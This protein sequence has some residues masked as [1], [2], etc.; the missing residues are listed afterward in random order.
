MI[1][2]QLRGMHLCVFGG[3][4]RSLCRVRL[5]MTFLLNTKLQYSNLT[6]PNNNITRKYDNADKIQSSRLSELSLSYI[7]HRP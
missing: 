4:S 7:F 6:T 1:V 2:Q 5:T 3:G